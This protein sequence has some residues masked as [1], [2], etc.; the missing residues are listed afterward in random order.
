MRALLQ[1]VARACVRVEEETV[2]QIGRGLL[3]FLGVARDDG[4]EDAEWLADKL[5]N[6][7]IFQNEDGKFDA[8]L[9]DVRGQ[10][11]VVSQ[12]TLYGDVGKGRRPSFSQAASPELAEELYLF[13]ADRIAGHGV[14][15]SRGRF[16]ARM[17]VDLVNEGPVTIM[18]DSRSR[19]SNR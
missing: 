3:I 6:L 14:P 2:G 9:L 10:A 1:R 17:F 13:V 16:G 4:R 18:V 7:R 5:V 15:V 11:L 19:R 12:F 8:S